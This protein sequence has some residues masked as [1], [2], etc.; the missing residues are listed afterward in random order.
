LLRRPLRLL[1]LLPL[2]L[3][4][5]LRPLL[6]LRLWG[7]LRALFLLFLIRLRVRRRQRPH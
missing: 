4:S 2:L 6:L 5:R 7:R 3:W 1:R